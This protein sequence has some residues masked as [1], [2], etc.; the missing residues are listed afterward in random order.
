MRALLLFK[1]LKPSQIT[2]N[3]WYVY[4]K[5][6]LRSALGSKELRK[7]TILKQLS[8]LKLPYHGEPFAYIAEIRSIQQAITA[9]N[10]EM[11]DVLQY[12]ALNGMNESFRNTF[13]LVTQNLRPSVNDIVT[14]FFEVTERFEATKKPQKFGKFGQETKDTEATTLGTC[15]DTSSVNKMS[16]A[17]SAS[18]K[19][20]ALQQCRLCGA[21]SEKHP[22]YRCTVHTVSNG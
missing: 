17:A 5:D 13:T 3:D 2:G 10:I 4:A 16:T 1:D 20:N 9:L 15:T 21:K 6:Y 11:Q 19:Q 14:K 12:F 18:S 22:I 8:E 7:F